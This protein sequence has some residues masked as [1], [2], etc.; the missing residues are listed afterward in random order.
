MRSIRDAFKNWLGDKQAIGIVAVL[1]TSEDP[2]ATLQRYNRNI[3]AKV[4]EGLITHSYYVAKTE[5][6]EKALVWVDVAR[7]AC[8]IGGGAKEFADCLDWR[9]ILLQKLHEKSAANEGSQEPGTRSLLLEALACAEEALR[10][11][12]KAKVEE[13]LPPAYGRV[14]ILYRSLEKTLPAFENRLFSVIGWSK[15]SDASDAMPRLIGDFI[16]LFWDL[17]G[18]D[19]KNAARMLLDHTSALQEAIRWLDEERRGGLFDIFGVACQ[20]LDQEEEAILWWNQAL[21]QYRSVGAQADEFLILS[22]LQD[23]AYHFAKPE[24]IVEYGRQCVAA[25]PNDTEPRR[26]ASRYH[27]LAFGYARL[28][29]DKEAISAYHDAADLYSKDEE[30]KGGVTDCL[31]EAGIIEEELGMID[32]AQE[33]LEK[34]LN[35]P[36]TASGYWLASLTLAEL[37]WRR[38]GDL[39]AAIRNAD[40]AVELSITMLDLTTRTV[41]HQLSGILHLN[42]GNNEKALSRFDSLLKI[43]AKDP[44]E[45]SVSPGRLSRHAVVPPSKSEAALFALVAAQ[46]LNRISDAQRY[47]AQYRSFLLEAPHGTFSEEYKDLSLE[48]ADSADLFLGARMLTQGT[49]LLVVDPRQAA[50]VL[51]Q[52]LPL[53]ENFVP[54][55]AAVHFNLGLARLRL[56]ELELARS[57]FNRSLELLVR[58]PDSYAEMGCRLNLGLTEARSGNFRGA[59]DHFST[60]IRLKEVQRAT[61][62]DVDQRLLF[63]QNELDNYMFFIWICL[64]LRFFRDAL[65]TIE[66]IKSRLFLDM[67]GQPNKRPIDYRSLHKIKELRRKREDWDGDFI[68]ETY[69]SRDRRQ[70]ELMQTNS[71]EAQH[72]L[73]VPVSVSDEIETTK[74][75]LQAHNFF[76][77][78]ES[79]AVSLSFGEIRGLC[80]IC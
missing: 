70:Q 3:D 27:F 2:I 45:S 56:G 69:A 65:E 66:K 51:E 54:G 72:W 60:L 39:G 44:E 59:Y 31:L 67:L 41:S 30:G 32:Q 58:S 46:R 79:Q 71:E 38:R 40:R 19:L 74:R 28:E 63:L 5:S 49:Q 4:I 62:T 50:A 64:K 7:Q 61:L 34:V 6:L 24:L 68:T 26:L 22:R 10:V 43:L 13:K 77:E 55:S 53:L 15:L 21:E 48:D 75:E 1:S 8:L 11:Y 29:R 33:D 12:E 52:S 78:L 42:A 14:S 73:S 18:D 17:E 16:G 37:L 36:G 76:V 57:C 80:R 47:F 35:L 23:S 9:A 25:A 20:E